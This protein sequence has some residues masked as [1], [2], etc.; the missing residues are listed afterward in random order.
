MNYF[1][2]YLVTY[3]DKFIGDDCRGEANKQTRALYSI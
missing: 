2:T 1:V 3:L